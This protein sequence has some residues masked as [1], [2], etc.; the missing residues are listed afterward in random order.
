MAK[1]VLDVDGIRD[2][3]G[4]REVLGELE[5]KA[6][7]LEIGGD[8]VGEVRSYM[9]VARW[10]PKRVNSGDADSVGRSQEAV[11]RLQAGVD[12][13]MAVQMST[14]K[15]VRA[16]GKL[17]VLVRQELARVGVINGRTSGAGARQA[18][19]LVVPELAIYQ[20]TWESFEKLCGNVL[21]HLGDAK[22]TVRLQ[23]KLDENANWTR[24]YSGS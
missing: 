18:V 2:R 7:V 16:L 8:L 12:R 22:D 10:I 6:E 19:G 21:K 5:R 23:I 4:V 13:M 11:H 17:E 3:G 14:M 24:R 1:E 15:V 9:D 20:Q